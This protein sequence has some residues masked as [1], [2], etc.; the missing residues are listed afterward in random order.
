LVVG[1]LLCVGGLVLVGGG[2]GGSLLDMGSVGM[3]LAC[4]AF[5]TYGWRPVQFP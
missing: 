2:G 1:C 4:H 3:P 5:C